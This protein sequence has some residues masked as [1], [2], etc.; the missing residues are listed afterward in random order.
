M[1]LIKVFLPFSTVDWFVAGM[2]VDRY[3]TLVVKTVVNKLFVF[4]SQEI[5]DQGDIFYLPMY[6]MV[7]SKR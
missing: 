1:L 3:P 7:T 4:M 6:N 2:L 5:L